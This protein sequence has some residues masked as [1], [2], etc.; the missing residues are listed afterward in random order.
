MKVTY[1]GVTKNQSEWADFFGVTRGAITQRMYEYK[2]TADQAV[3]YFATRVGTGE[4][5]QAQKRKE[6]DYKMSSRGLLVAILGELREMNGAGKYGLRA[7][8]SIDAADET[9][10]AGDSL[11]KE[12]DARPVPAPPNICDKANLVI[13]EFE[14]VATR[15]PDGLTVID[16][17]CSRLEC[18]VE[19]L[20][21]ALGEASCERKLRA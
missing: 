3:R 8:S 7:R 20:K 14:K 2:E 13:R 11:L 15:R 5:H 12:E 18:A 21:E 19:E 9:R 6:A 4:K 17:E 1:K 10:V 16:C